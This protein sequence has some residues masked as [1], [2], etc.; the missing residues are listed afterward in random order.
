MGSDWER[1]SPPSRGQRLLIF[2]VVALAMV[3][4]GVALLSLL[5]TALARPATVT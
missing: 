5:Y 3:I 2:A 4:V 1:P